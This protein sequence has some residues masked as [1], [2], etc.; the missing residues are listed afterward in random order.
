[1][2]KFGVNDSDLIEGLRNEEHNLMLEVAQYMNVM[3][4]TAEEERSFKRAQ[5]RLQQVRD[6]IT[7]HDLKKTEPTW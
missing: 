5:A 3:E 7:E 1:M 6:K 2:E 4:K